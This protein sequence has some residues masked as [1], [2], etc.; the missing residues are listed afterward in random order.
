MARTGERTG[1]ESEESL[2]GGAACQGEHVWPTH[3]GPA[4]R[5]H[6]GGKKK[7]PD[8]WQPIYRRRLV[9]VSTPVAVLMMLGIGPA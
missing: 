5:Q 7:P 3:P 1:A 8:S 6:G 9:G 2:V 4:F